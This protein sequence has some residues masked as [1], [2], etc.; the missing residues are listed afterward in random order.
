[1]GPL[2]PVRVEEEHGTVGVGMGVGTVIYKRAVRARG[3]GL[4]KFAYCETVGV[5]A[6][7][8]SY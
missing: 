1:M 4:S 8:A 2:P 6:L 3:Y 5:G 7:R